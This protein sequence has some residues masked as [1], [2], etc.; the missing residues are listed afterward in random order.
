MRISLP[1]KEIVLT[2]CANKG[3]AIVRIEAQQIADACFANKSSVL[4]WVRKVERGEIIV[5][6]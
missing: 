1:I 5:S 4:N 3:T 6:A 2:A